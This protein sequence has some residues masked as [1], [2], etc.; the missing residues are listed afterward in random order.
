MSGNIEY[1]GM[2]LN[3]K[4]DGYGILYI[5]NGSII[6]DTWLNGKSLNNKI[7]DINCCI[8]FEHL[9]IIYIL[10]PC[11]HSQICYKCIDKLDHKC[12][13]CTKYFDNHIR[14]FL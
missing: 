9:N 1:D 3:G 12:P 6:N 4:Y 13:I 8:C 7:H 11:G 10:I 5:E 2:W 14:V